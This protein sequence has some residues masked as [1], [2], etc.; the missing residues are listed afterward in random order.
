MLH[1]IGA[2]ST[3]AFVVWLIAY[4]IHKFKEIEPTKNW[5]FVM[6]LC[7]LAM[8]IGNVLAL[9]AGELLGGILLLLTVPMTKYYWDMWQIRRRG[10]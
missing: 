9:M 4:A 7:G 3:I 2:I 1:T 5:C 8:T 10:W 6:M